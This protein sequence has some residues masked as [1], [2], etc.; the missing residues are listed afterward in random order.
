LQVEQLNALAT[1]DVGT[2][3]AATDSQHVVEP[4]PDA[5][6]LGITVAKQQIVVIV[7]VERT[8]GSAHAVEPKPAVFSRPAAVQQQQQFQ[9]REQ[10]ELSAAKQPATRRRVE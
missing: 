6:E 9:Q 2:A 4:A 8:S 1:A 5:A 3:A 7:V 10:F